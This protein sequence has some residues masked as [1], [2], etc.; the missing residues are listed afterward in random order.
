[1]FKTTW[2]S[3]EEKAQEITKVDN[4]PSMVEISPKFDVASLLQSMTKADAMSILGFDGYDVEEDEEAAALDEISAF[5]NDE[6]DAIDRLEE[7]KMAAA[8]AI[9]KKETSADGEP[10]HSSSQSAD[11]SKNSD[12]AEQNPAQVPVGSPSKEGEQ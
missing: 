3:M 7:A 11:K 8:K 10:P 6:A 5:E 4:T 12:F 1:M 2:K 9:F